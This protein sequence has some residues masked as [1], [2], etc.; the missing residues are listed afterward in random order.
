[1]ML[2]LLT[3]S[4]FFMRLDNFKNS[5]KRSIDEVVYYRMAEQVLSEGLAGYHT[6]PYGNYL[7]A[8]GRPLPEYFFQPLF[9]HPPLFTLLTASSMKIFGANFISAGFVPIAMSVLM[10]PLIY[11]LGATIYDQRVGILAAVFLCIDPINIITSQKVWMDTTIAFFV[12]LAAFFFVLG[13]KR[14]NDWWFILSGLASGLAVNTKYTGIFIT[15]IIAVYCLLYRRDLFARKQFQL[16]LLLPFILLIPWLYWNYLIYGIT[17][18]LKHKEIQLVAM[19][20]TSYMPVM[21]SLAALVVLLVFILKRKKKIILSENN[22]NDASAQQRLA[23]TLSII[24]PVLFFMFIVPKQFLHS[25]QWSYLPTHSWSQGI[26]SGEP[27]SFYFGRLLE[28]SPLYIL[29]FVAV[30]LYHPDEK[31]ETPFIRLSA[32]IILL[33]FIFWGNYQSR[34]ILSCLPF[35]ILLGAQWL[36]NFY[37]RAS[38]SKNVIARVGGRIITWMVLGFSIFKIGYINGMVSYPNDLCYF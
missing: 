2:G 3:V 32:M 35:L 22:L 19:K 38:G 27:P 21:L 30:F 11:F 18:I 7:A 4:A 34:Y 17:S 9:K 1:M 33:F 37:Y 13:V 24:V 23:G 5:T 14:N 15:L 29:S 10:I 26:F 25:L 28:F 8:Q 31:K 6:I 36:E 12:L 20:I 16:S